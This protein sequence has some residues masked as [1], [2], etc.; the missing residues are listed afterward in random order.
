MAVTPFPGAVPVTENDLSPEYS[1]DALALEFSSRHTSEL[2]YCDPWGAWLLWDGT[3]WKPENVKAFDMARSVT[4]EFANACH[5]PADGPK[6]ASAGKVA[7]IERLARS[8]RRHATETELWD[9]TP[10]S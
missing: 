10:G 6:I 1:D 4:R 7:A 5:N 9:T 2:R 3:R 8:D